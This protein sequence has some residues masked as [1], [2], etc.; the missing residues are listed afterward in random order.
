MAQA[1]VGNNDSSSVFSVDLNKQSMFAQNIVAGAIGKLTA[2]IQ[3][4]ESMLKKAESQNTT[5]FAKAQDAAAKT[6]REQ[7]TAEL[8]GGIA[9]GV[10]G[11]GAA[12]IG[13]SKLMESGKE[14]AAYGTEMK[15]LNAEIDAASEKVA[16]H[17]EIG[18][19]G[20]TATAE[21]EERATPEMKERAKAELDALKSKKADLQSAHHEKMQ[22][23]QSAAQ[24][25]SSFS[26]ASTELS[27]A[28]T[29]NVTKHKD[30]DVTTKQADAQVQKVAE[31]ANKGSFD[32]LAGLVKGA[33][34]VEAGLYQS[35]AAAA[36]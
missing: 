5:S 9:G 14:M 6:Q 29:T 22:S 25:A 11:F 31:G 32:T 10:A 4:L 33:Q 8:I 13:A 35:S 28:S 20:E 19:Q 34:D 7:G 17:A 3:M 18:T 30:A 24:V 1:N 36:R 16:E 12:G 23:F 15:P 26:T 2:F 27:R 21:T